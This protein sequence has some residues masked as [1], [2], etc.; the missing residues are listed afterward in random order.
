VS[1]LR[2]DSDPGD[3]VQP[4]AISF[5]LRIGSFRTFHKALRFASPGRTRSP[6][7]NI[8]I[9]ILEYT[10]LA[11]AEARGQVPHK[12]TARDPGVAEIPAS[13]LT[14]E[15]TGELLPMV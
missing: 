6:S 9:Y 1:G 13:G 3:G 15:A 4:A 5:A 10:G 7:R 12:Q 14:Y 2:Q 8:Y 11:D